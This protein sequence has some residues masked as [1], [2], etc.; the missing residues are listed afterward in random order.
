MKLHTYFISTRLL[1]LKTQITLFKNRFLTYGAAKPIGY[2][3]PIM[4]IYFLKFRQNSSSSFVRLKTSS[5]HIMAATYIGLYLFKKYSY[6][7]YVS[8]V[9]GP[10]CQIHQRRYLLPFPRIPDGNIPHNYHSL[11]WRLHF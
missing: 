7:F 3:F 1:F 4:I 5:H 11:H 10:R 9:I 2:I 6:L 8:T